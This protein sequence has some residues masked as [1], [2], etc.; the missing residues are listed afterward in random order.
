MAEELA[1]FGEGSL[2][3]WRDLAMLFH[4]FP[5]LKADP[6]QVRERL[7]ATGASPAV[8]ATWDELAAQ[9]IQSPDED[10]EFQ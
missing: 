7:Q 5:E 2:T 8:L 3:F 9:E 1:V 6:T 10:A 4:A